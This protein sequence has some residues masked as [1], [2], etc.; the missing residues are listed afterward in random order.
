MKNGKLP[1]LHQKKILKAHG[2]QL[3]SWLVVKDVGK[4]LEIV[5]RAELNRCR[6]ERIEGKKRKPKT[7]I[8]EKE[9]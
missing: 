6:M 2:L 4:S 8:I 3:D 9:I 7:R 5:S 1:T